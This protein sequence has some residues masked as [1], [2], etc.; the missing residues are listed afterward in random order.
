MQI[1]P[2]KSILSIDSIWTSEHSRSP[3]DVKTTIIENRNRTA[4]GTL[5]AYHIANKHELSLSWEYLPSTSEYTVDGYA[6]GVELKQIF[7]DQRTKFVEIWTGLSAAKSNSAPA[8][9][10]DAIITEFSYSVEKRNI[11][12]QFYDFWNV[13]MS[14]EEI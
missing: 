10:F 13:S 9:A 12:G 1:F 8:L 2:A 5:R 4:N 3:L 7:D 14:L 11:G 6:G